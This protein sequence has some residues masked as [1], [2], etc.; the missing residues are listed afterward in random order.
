MLP[1]DWRRL[2]M[3]FRAA[4]PALAAPELTYPIA[5]WA[6]TGFGGSGWFARPLGTVVGAVGSLIHLRSLKMACALDGYFFCRYWSRVRLFS[7]SPPPP[8]NSRASMSPMAIVSTGL[9]GAGRY[10][11]FRRSKVPTNQNS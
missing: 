2:S 8:P 9:H 1:V 7:S 6:L 10:G 4:A 5:R 11:P 3:A